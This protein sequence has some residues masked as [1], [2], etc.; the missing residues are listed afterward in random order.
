MFVICTWYTSDTEIW[1]LAVNTASLRMQSL[2]NVCGS[3]HSDNQQPSAPSNHWSMPYKSC[4]KSS[5]TITNTLLCLK[6]EILP[7]RMGAV[8]THGDMVIG[9]STYCYIEGWAEV[10]FYCSVHEVF[11][12]YRL[13]VLRWLQAGW[14]VCV[15]VCVCECV[16]VCVSS[17]NVLET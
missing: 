1:H 2:N 11:I 4:H 14:C 12:D 10:H 7:E 17:D 15:C 6:Q 5:L 13:G 3:V 16:C 9:Y 8:A